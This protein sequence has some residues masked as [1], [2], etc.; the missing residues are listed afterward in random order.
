MRNLLVCAI[1]AATLSATPVA[2]QTAPDP[3]EP[4]DSAFQFEG[5][6]REIAQRV[7]NHYRVMKREKVQV[8][9]LFSSPY[10]WP[11]T[12]KKINVCFLD[13]TPAERAD[14]VTIAAEWTQIGANLPLDFG[15]KAAPRECQSGG[16]AQHV[17]ITL[18]PTGMVWS[19]VGRQSMHAKLF[20]PDGPSMSL[21]FAS[22]TSSVKR[23][24]SIRHEF[25]HAIGL[26]HE[27]QNPKLDCW[28]RHY[29]QQKLI[30]YVQQQFQWTEDDVKLQLRVM[31]EP[32]LIAT[33][34]DRLSL[35]LYGFPARFYRT[36]SQSDCFA[37][38]NDMIS[39][40]DKALVREI[41][42]STE[43]KRVEAIERRAQSLTALRSRVPQSE[44]NI[45]QAQ[46]LSDLQM[47]LNPD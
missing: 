47:F 7:A 32:G 5:L 21:G 19:A 16:E 41:Y 10:L 15:E 20:P 45:Q 1:I 35:M 39:P 23:K 38:D 8:R 34:P 29:D 24:R 44:R 2:T 36:G 27:H 11:L 12:L 46:E 9:G 42:P 26:Q 37:S 31:E 6:P 14:V 18:K 3:V 13:G 30:A 40:S 43:S 33:E 28:A 17:R 4:D 25:G 22:T